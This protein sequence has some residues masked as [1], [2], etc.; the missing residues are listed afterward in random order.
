MSAV[1]DLEHGRDAYGRESWGDAFE[2]LTAADRSGVSRADVERAFRGWKITD[3]EIA[4][5]EPDPIARIFKFDER[6]YRLR[7]KGARA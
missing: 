3:V 4:D 5:S 7:R 2:S 6:F 1:A